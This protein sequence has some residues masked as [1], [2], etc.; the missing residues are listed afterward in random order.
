MVVAAL[1]IGAL[2][3]GLTRFSLG[4]HI[5]AALCQITSLG[6]GDCAVAET[7]ARAA[8]DY[9]PPQP[10]VKSGDGGAWE[11]SVAFGVQVEGGK[12]WFVE[13]LGD[14]RYRLT[15]TGTVGVGVE[16]GLGIDASAVVNDNRY[17]VALGLGGA[18]T[19][20]LKTGD[21][22]Y[23]TSDEEAEAILSAADSDDL[24]DGSVGDHWFGR[25]FVDWVTN[26]SDLEQVEAESTFVK[27]GVQASGDLYATLIDFDASATAEAGTYVGQTQ[28]RDG[29]TMDLYTASSSG[30][31][32]ASGSIGDEWTE[33][34]SAVASYAGAV[35][36]E[37]DRDADGVPTAMRLVTLGSGYADTSSTNNGANDELDSV[38][39]TEQT[40]Q[41]P[42]GTV[43]QR[44]TAG[45]LALGLGIE[46]PGV[47]QE[48]SPLDFSTLDYGETWAGFKDTAK[49]HGYVW[50]QN[51]ALNDS[52][53]GG[54]L[55]VEALVKVGLSGEYTSRSRTATGYTYWDG[56]QFTTRSG[57]L[58]E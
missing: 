13:A 53:N 49:T 4:E 34:G 56:T 38:Q 45:K 29:R 6:Q 11:G 35:T 36:I 2:V 24:K 58:G 21:V 25:D 41:V 19:D 39:Y 16:G 52:T 15:R 43:E 33:F 55:D 1:L 42:L 51:Y 40:W 28:Y 32:R 5:S 8:E 20:Q 10:C 3:L 50:E 57:C 37:V 46:V 23:A 47:T 26:A 7:P 30:V 14:G 22:Y 48:I 44:I 27:V 9:V 54:N 12:T 18:I 17:G 31:A